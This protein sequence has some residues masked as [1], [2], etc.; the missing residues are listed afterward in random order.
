MDDFMDAG[1][2]AIFV[3]GMEPAGK[4]FQVRTDLVGG[5]AKKN[6]E[7]GV[8]PETI[9]CQ[10]QV[11]DGIVGGA[12]DQLEPFIAL[13]QCLLSLPPGGDI[14]EAPNPADTAAGNSLGM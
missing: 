3:L 4:R 2:H 1:D 6:L 7:P 10:V 5:V 9:G 13:P 11:P 8:P 14:A 12:S